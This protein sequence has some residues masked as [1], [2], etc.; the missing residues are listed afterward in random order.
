MCTKIEMEGDLLELRV[1][2]Y[3]LAVAEE[4]SVTAAAER[5]HLSQ[6]ALTKQLKSL[7]EELSTRLFLRGHK[8]I[9]LTQDGELLQKRALEI[10]NLTEKTEADILRQHR[11]ISG[12]VYL[13]V[14]EISSLET[15]GNAIKLVHTRF[16]QIR[17]HLSYGD[18]V[19]SVAR[20]DR[21]LQDFALIGSQMEDNRY[22]SIL[23]TRQDHWGIIISKEHPLSN[24]RKIGPMDLRHV[25]L[26]LTR[27]GGASSTFSSWLGYSAS[28]L[29]VIGT[30]DNAHIALPLVENNTCACVI[31]KR[32]HRE[33]WGE[34]VRFIPFDP[35]LHI[36]NSLIWP[37]GQTMSE[38]GAIF[39]ETV[40]ELVEP[41]AK[42]LPE[43]LET[44]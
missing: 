18:A 28:R 19:D 7:E 40:R 38:A 32:Y 39:L 27:Q 17:F 16:P 41:Y 43:D 29:N 37:K 31:L 34:T 44:E 1:L 25:P 23:F 6:P 30:F 42:A 15:I 33:P 35:P 21:G 5:L 14:A 8:G 13:A 20:L 4:G 24:L 2:K 9:T 3:F 26:L 12:D 36:A 11:E 10:V 22:N